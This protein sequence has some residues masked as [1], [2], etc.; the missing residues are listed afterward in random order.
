M[1]K[2]ETDIVWLR[3]DL[4]LVDN[5]AISNAIKQ[6]STITFLFIFDTNIISELPNDDPRVTFIYD[7]LL[8]L[9]EQLKAHNATLLIRIGKPLDIW[10]D[11][12]NEFKIQRV[13]INE[14]YE[15]YGIERD[16]QVQM[17]FKTNNIKLIQSKDHV[18]FK[19]GEILKKDDT[20]YTVYTAYKNKWLT[21][22]KPQRIETILYN[23]QGINKSE[24]KTP[25]LADL[26][27]KRS[28]IDV[29]KYSFDVINTYNQTRDYPELPTSH[30]G[31]FLRFGVVSIREAMQEALKNDTYL[32][33]LI[34][35]EF[36]IQV[37][38]YFPHTV[39]ECF[40]SKYNR[41][42]WLNNS[43]LFEQWCSGNTGYPLV[44]AGMRELNA[45]GFMH[46]RVRMVCASFMCKHLLID[47]RWG[48]AYFAKKLFDF[49]L[50]SNIGNWQWVAGTGCDAAPYF[51]V[52]NPDIQAS[53]FDINNKYIQKWVPEY[54]NSTY[55]Q[56][57]VNHKFARER[58][59]KAYKDVL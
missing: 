32:L 21:H 8:S 24:F 53:K 7:T 50:A 40:R 55:P 27:F 49:E 9:N 13:Y 10:K 45:T 41:I 51:R 31:T 36:F 23:L 46:N 12:T 1:G 44:D 18:V 38:Y 42:K 4:R 47:W 30:I 56:Q 17:Y 11:L 58:A 2:I 25:T 57:I 37:L 29:P 54:G 52:F 59:I 22:L 39:S 34:W 35:R 33:E 26:G 19:P 3:R 43:V 6:K 15:P 14:D 28:S 5:V 20:P 16:R 48:E